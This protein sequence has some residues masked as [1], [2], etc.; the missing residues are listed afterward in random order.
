ME[1]HGW[2]TEYYSKWKKVDRRGNIMYDSIIWNS[3]KVQTTVAESLYQQY[4]GLEG[5]NYLQRS[6]RKFWW[7]ECSTS[8]L[9]WW[10]WLYTFFKVHPSIQLKW[11]NLTLCKLYLNKGELK[12]IYP[13]TNPVK[14][15]TNQLHLTP[16]F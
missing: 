5:G 6:K 11:M 15:F 13:N 2:I 7:W 9:W 10:L 8:W 16:F 3:E 14:C 4:L 1:Q 12:L